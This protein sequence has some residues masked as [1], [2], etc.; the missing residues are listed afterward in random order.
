MHRS[1]N[2][3]PN[4]A[5]TIVTILPSGVFGA[6]LPYPARKKNTNNKSNKKIDYIS[7]KN[8]NFIE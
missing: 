6:K 1:I 7:I 2:G 8:N 3:T 4:N 5:Y